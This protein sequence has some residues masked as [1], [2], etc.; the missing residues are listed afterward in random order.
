MEN[1]KLKPFI[2]L[3]KGKRTALLEL[4]ERDNIVKKKADKGGAV[5]I[6]DMNDYIKYPES[7]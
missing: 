5:V 7:N 4:K 2:S 6:I 3:T 1:Q